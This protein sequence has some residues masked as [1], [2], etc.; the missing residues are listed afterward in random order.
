MNSVMVRQAGDDF[1]AMQ[2]AHAMQSIE[3]VEVISIVFQSERAGDPTAMSFQRPERWHVFAKYDS[4]VVSPDQVD[5]A[6][7]AVFERPTG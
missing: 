5:S 3:G 1:L 4:N 6:I 2:T 7:D